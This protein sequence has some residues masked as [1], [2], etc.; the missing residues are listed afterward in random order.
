MKKYSGIILGVCSTIGKFLGIDP[1][2]IRI[3]AIIFFN[4][5]VTIYVVLAIIFSIFLDENDEEKEKRKNRK[6]KVQKKLEE[7]KTEYINKEVFENEKISERRN[8]GK[9]MKN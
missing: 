5:V 8:G 2:L 3:I 1:W 6:V 9:I 4:D 7:S